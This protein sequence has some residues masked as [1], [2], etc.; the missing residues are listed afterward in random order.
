[1]RVVVPF[2][3]IAPGV[4]EALA[5][6]GYVFE[7]RDVS[8]S[9]SAY[10]DLLE[11]LWAE[12]ETFTIVEHDIIVRPDTPLELDTC[13]SPWCGFSVPY[14]NGVHPGM[15]CVKFGAEL[16]ARAPFAV[17]DAGAMSDDRHPARHWC[18][19]DASLQWMV[20]PRLQIPKHQHP[21]VL[22]HYRP[23]EGRP[24]PSHG[25]ISSSDLD[26]A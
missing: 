26:W 24:Q 19:L 7:L 4:F 23:Y 18:R 11:E 10:C 17:A 9:D 3:T 13:P 22:G 6:T 16:M 15:G 25:C 1:M 14:F 21:T 2:T 12:G 20:L 8:G 5:L